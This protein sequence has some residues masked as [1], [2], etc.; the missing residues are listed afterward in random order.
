MTCDEV[1]PCPVPDGA[2]VG[3]AVE[4]VEHEPVD[5]R[6]ALVVLAEANWSSAHDLFVVVLLA[7]EVRARDVE[8][9]HVLTAQHGDSVDGM[10]DGDRTTGDIVWLAV[11]L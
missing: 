7:L 6:A 1:V 11:T 8:R 2:A 5:L 10:S 3:L 4:R 9:T